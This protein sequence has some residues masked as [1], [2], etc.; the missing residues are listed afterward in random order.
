L[1]TTIINRI[2][3]Y[4]TP[5]QTIGIA[6]IAYNPGG[7]DLTNSIGLA[8]ARDM[9]E[10][11]YK[12]SVFDPASKFLLKQEDEQFKIMETLDELVIASDAIVIGTM[13]PEI[14]A[15]YRSYKGNKPIEV[16]DWRK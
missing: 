13:W 3:A 10:L 14:S 8:I 5:I 6:G 12:V 9:V 1:K 11:G 2:L 7:L 15:W 4:N 16:A